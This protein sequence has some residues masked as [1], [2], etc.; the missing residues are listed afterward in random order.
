MIK[1]EFPLNERVRKFLRIEEIFNKISQQLRIKNKFDDY[2]CFNLYFCT[3]ATASRTDLKVELIQELEKQRLIISKKSKTKKNILAQNELR[4]LKV[5]LEKS[6]IKTGFNFGGDK[7]LHELKTRSSSPSGIVMTDFPELQYWIGTTSQTDRKKYFIT[8]MG[9]YMPVKNAIKALMDI[10]RNNT[11]SELMSSKIETVQYKLNSR[12]K[13]DL[14]MITLPEKSMYYPNISAN[15]YAVNIHFVS[16]VPNS[17]F[18][19]IKFR[20]GTTSF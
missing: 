2:V 13:N 5:G 4:K 17:S 20:L 10:L 6:K 14:V 18:K 1:Y 9:E 7:F 8:K 12:F 19:L 11:Q 3:M 15:K 16:T